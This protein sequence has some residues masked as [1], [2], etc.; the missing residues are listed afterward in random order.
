M[1]QE[2]D[3]NVELEIRGSLP[4]PVYIR[5]LCKVRIL[6]TQT[7]ETDTPGFYSFGNEDNRTETSSFNSIEKQ[8]AE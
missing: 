6:L 4:S 5:M 8:M 1:L 3:S 7:K 2:E